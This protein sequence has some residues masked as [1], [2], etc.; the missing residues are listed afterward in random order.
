MEK[1][2]QKPSRSLLPTFRKFT[3]GPVLA[4]RVCRRA[5]RPQELVKVEC[6][7][8]DSSEALTQPSSA[9]SEIAGSPCPELPRMPRFDAFKMSVLRIDQQARGNRERRALCLTGQPAEAERAAEP[10]RPAENLGGE[11]G[12]AGELC[13]TTAQDNPRLRLCRK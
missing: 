2:H 13:R 11:F 10:D 7:G 1:I 12:K 4:C 5:R 6:N 8:K 3:P 9:F